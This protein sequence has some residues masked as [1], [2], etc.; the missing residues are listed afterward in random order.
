MI[1]QIRKWH[2]WCSTEQTLKRKQASGRWANALKMNDSFA[3]S[4]ADSFEI[5]YVYL[6]QTILKS[7][8]FICI[9]SRGISVT[10][11]CRLKCRF[12]S[13]ETVGL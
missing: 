4:G 9:F 8:V 10:V 5:P 13:T 7:L 12:T 6:V 3:K 2:K 11:P 1:H